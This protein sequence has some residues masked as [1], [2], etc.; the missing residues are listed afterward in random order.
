MNFIRTEIEGV[1]LIEPN[2]LH[3][4]RGEFFRTYDEKLFFDMGFKKKFVQHNHSN[5]FR[6][7][8]W[9]GFHYQLPPYA[10][11]KLIQCV[12]GKVYDVVLDIRKGSGTFLQWRGF[13]L[14]ALNK[15][16]V[17]IPEGCAHGFLTM[18]DDAVL[19]YHHTQFY[20]KEAEA[21]IRF[22]DPMIKFKMAAE[23]NKISIR[24]QSYTFLQ[25]D[26]KGID[27]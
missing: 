26:F 12:S 16:Q 18:E 22:D 1:Y 14:S 21:G 15:L 19:V 24:D 2:V 7:G 6:K 23:M 10:E 25:P 3:D 4:D 20:N 27:L 5:N 17:I 11:T 13:E 9:R 8:T